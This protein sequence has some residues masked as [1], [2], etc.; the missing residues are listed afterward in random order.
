M[1]ENR[2]LVALLEEMGV[3]EGRDA[4]GRPVVGEQFLVRDPEERIFADGA[5]HDGL[6]LA[7]GASADDL[8]QRARFQTEVDRWVSFRDDRGRRAFAIPMAHASDAPECTALDRISMRAWMDA[9]GFTSAR[10]RWLVDYACRDDYGLRMDEASAWAG[11]FYFASR[12]ERPGSAA[13]PLIAW[14]EGNGRLVSHMAGRLG[15]RLRLGELVLDIDDGSTNVTLTTVDA[16]S[17]TTRTIVAEHVVLATPA[18]VTARIV[19]AFRDH[20]PPHFAPFS[21]APWMVANLTLRDRPRENTSEMAWDNV[22][23]ESPS[24]GYVCA[25]HQTLRDD[26]AT[27]LTYYLPLTG[28]DVRRERTRLLTTGWD[29]W[30]SFALDDLSRAHGDLPTLVERIDV[31]RWGHG[32]IRPTVGFV[33]GPERVRASVPISPRIVPAHSD[34]SGLALF[35]EAQY[36]GVLAAETVLAS[37]GL[38]TEPLV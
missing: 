17:G 36:R 37:R 15:T 1:P 27:V 20:A 28:A 9:H 31:C 30:C 14:P 19:R 10:L 21:Y 6:Y 29:A 8:G 4:D 35:E 3:V 33:W 2:A 25:T 24:L 22:L 23:Y 18:F 12:V 32:M 7:E 34:L 16:T 13:Q 26:G 11:I 5:W 38:A